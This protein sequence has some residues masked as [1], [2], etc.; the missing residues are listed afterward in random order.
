M[1][2][3]GRSENISLNSRSNPFSSSFIVSDFF[4]F[5][6]TKTKTYVFVFEAPRNQ[7]LG[8]EEDYIAVYRDKLRLSA[9]NTGLA[10]FVRQ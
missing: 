7:D 4:K 1:V 5:C 2:T 6:Q 8:L 9:I 10:P 3:P